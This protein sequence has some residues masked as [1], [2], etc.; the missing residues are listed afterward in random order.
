MKGTDKVKRAAYE[1][2]VDYLLKD[3]EHNIVK[4]MDLLDMWLPRS[5]SALS[6][7]RSAALS[8]ARAIGIALS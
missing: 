5:C 3:P 8:T 2:A 1:K 6:A 4:I 7:R